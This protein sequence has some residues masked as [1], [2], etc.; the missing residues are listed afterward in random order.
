MTQSDLEAC[1]AIEVQSYPPTVVEGVAVF[2]REL[3]HHPASCWVADDGASTAVGYA[4]SM[5]ARESDC[6]LELNASEEFALPEASDERRTL[7]LHDIAVAKDARRAGVGALLLRRVLDHAQEAGLPCITLTA[8]CGGASYWARH[9][10]A[11]VDELSAAAQE[12]LRSYP[13]ECGDVRVMQLLLTEAVPRS[14]VK[15]LVDLPTEQLEQLLEHVAGL[16][17]ARTFAAFARVSRV[18]GVAATRSLHVAVPSTVA[19]RLQRRRHAGEL[20]CARWPGMAL[21]AGV[22]TIFEDAFRD[23]SKLVAITLPAS[24][25]AIHRA[26]FAGCTALATVN[27]PARGTLIASHAFAGCAALTSFT[28]PDGATCVDDYTF[29]G[30]TALTKIVIPD[31]VDCI[32]EGAFENCLA[33]TVVTLPDSTV[34]INQGAFGGCHALAS[35]NLPNI[36]DIGPNAFFDCALLDDA[37]RKRIGAINADAL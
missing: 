31:G 1:A 29:A 4:I 6:P 37:T 19:Q 15:T 9:G 36:E 32:C 30:C 16:L 7:Y 24:V 33:M 25:T 27:L 35:I 12:R 23:C 22:T 14:A 3:K 8:V 18:F 2:A 5:P 17:P 28:I 10:F 26:A 11:P 13:A 34:S 21:P 20:T